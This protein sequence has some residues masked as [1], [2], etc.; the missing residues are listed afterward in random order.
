M[1][2]HHQVSHETR[3]GCLVFLISRTLRP[4]LHLLILV[5]LLL[6][7]DLVSAKP[8]FWEITKTSTVHSA[9]VQDHFVAVDG[10]RVHYIEAGAGPTVVMIHGNAGSVDDFEF[11][12][13]DIL[14]ADYHVLAVDRPGHGSSD[15][16]FG[17]VTVERQAE[18]LH[19]TLSN[20]SVTQPILVGHSWGASLALAYAL[21]Y[22]KE[23]S[24][25]ILLAP[26]AYPDMGG[27]GLLRA[28]V[29]IP[30][31]GD[32]GLF[33]T[34]KLIGHSMLKRALAQA[35][36]PQK[37]SDSYLKRAGSLWLGRRQI[38]AYI[39]DE[40][41]LNASLKIMSRRYSELSLPVVIVTGDQDKIVAVDQNARALHA[42]IP[43]SHLI[44]IKDTGHEIPQTHPESIET[45]LRLIVVPSA[46]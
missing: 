14:S 33:L 40:S 24:A 19:R 23:V 42:A 17:K 13:T 15:R 25:I 35:F 31:I 1:S 44:E 16:P 4:L 18:L 29:T 28:M 26:A 21:K 38:K 36:Y 30:V 7:S 10:L 32:G 5:S 8:S 39:E 2:V 41:S 43:Q 46:N 11:G 20:L 12:A 22:P 34:G 3:G 27:S 6:A 9:L 45:A 37:P